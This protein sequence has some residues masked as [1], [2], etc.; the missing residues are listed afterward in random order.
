MEFGSGVIQPQPV[1][2]CHGKSRRA[3]RNAR[4]GGHFVMDLRAIRE[5]RGSTA[6]GR[7]NGT[8]KLPATRACLGAAEI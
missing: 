2:A 3:S 7:F 4:A 5:I 8:A 1:N 6:P